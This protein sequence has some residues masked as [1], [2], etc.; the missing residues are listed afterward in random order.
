MATPQAALKVETLR[1]ELRSFTRD[2]ICAAAR[3][4]FST[5]GYATATLEQIAQAAGTRRSTVYNHFRDKNEILAAISEEYSHGMMR[6]IAR[7]PSPS[8]SR[9]AL[10]LWVAEIAAFTSAE[11]TPTELL[12]HIGDLTEMPA[13]LAALGG[14]IMVALGEK[15]PAFKQA[16]TPGPAQGLALARASAVLR[17]L[18]WACL[19]HMQ[20]VPPVRPEDML[21]VAAEY[22]EQFIS[23]YEDPPQIA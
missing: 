18:G 7:L 21:A 17:Q 14:R 4:M 11:R 9:A 5:H 23:E 16:V 13:A 12:I 15:L 1:D 8:P 3:E 6:L 20:P 10:D 2:R 19:H 22:F